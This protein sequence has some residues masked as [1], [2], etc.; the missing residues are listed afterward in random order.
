MEEEN[1]VEGKEKEMGCGRISCRESRGE[2][3]NCQWAEKSLGCAWD[4]GW[5]KIPGAIWWRL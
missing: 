1:C 5:V 3:K 4:L 2:N